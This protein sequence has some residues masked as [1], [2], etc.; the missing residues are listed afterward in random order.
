[1]SRRPP[2]PLRRA[3]PKAAARFWLAALAL[4]GACLCACSGCAPNLPPFDPALVGGWVAPGFEPVRDEFIRNFEQRGELGAAC[5]VY[6]DERKVVDLFGGYRDA[7][8]RAPWRE[9]TLVC[10]FSSTKG[11]SATA[12]AVAHSRGL[13]ELDAPVAT[14]WPEFAQQG[15]E[16]I[17]VR[18]LLAHQAGLGPL[19]TK[20]DPEALADHDRL[21]E[22]LARQKP[23]WRPGQRHGYH[24]ITLGLYEGALLR[25]IDPLGR[26]L[27]R[28]FADE[29]ARPL[30]AEFYIGLPERVPDTRLAHVLGYEPIELLFRA[31]TFP[32]AMVGALLCPWSITARTMAGLKARTAAEIA[33][34][35]YCRVEFP[36]A[37]GVCTARGLARLYAELAAGGRR[38]RLRADT[39]RELWAVPPPPPGGARDLVLHIDSAYTLGFSKRGAAFPQ[40]ADERCF[41][42]P[43][44]GGSLGLAD[45]E[46]GLGFAYVMNRMGTHLIDDPRERALRE[47]VYRCLSARSVRAATERDAALPRVLGRLY[48]PSHSHGG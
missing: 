18:Q 7:E 27:G 24:A 25:R 4:T 48:D 19:D 46:S 17:T 43:G 16:S 10:V 42:T 30:G 38:L 47:A 2:P 15:K 6:L 26:T 29:V 13:F 34:R 40:A 37:G 8:T 22:I 5:A 44:A 14:Y 3:E 28:F 31:N 36:S 35:P 11:M 33:T 41:G 21:A 20:L 32:P 9:D 45:P 23:A 1:L 12:L 39:L